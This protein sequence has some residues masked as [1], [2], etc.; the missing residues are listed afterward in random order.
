[1]GKHT[2]RAFKKKKI[3][4]SQTQPL[5]TMPWYTDLDGFLEHS[6]SGGG[7]HYKGSAPQKITLYIEMIIWLTLMLWTWLIT[8]IDLHMLNH[9]CIPGINPIWSQCT[10]PLMYCWLRFANILFDTTYVRR[11]SW[12]II[13]FPCGI[14]VWFWY[15]GDAGLV[16]WVWKCSLLSYFLEEFEKDWY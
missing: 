8:V 12:P 11:E 7:L 9:P 5:T 4:W 16:K 10:T 15:Q 1:M 3:C 6:P 14:F 13:F 2:E